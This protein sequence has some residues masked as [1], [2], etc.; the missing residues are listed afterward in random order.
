MCRNVLNEEMTR[1]KKYSFISPTLKFCI[2]GLFIPGFTAA[3][4]LGLQMAIGLFGA[5]CETAWIILWMLTS[6]GAVVAPLIFIRSMNKRLSEGYNLTTKK[7]IFFNITEYTFIQATLAM[8][9]TNRHTL[10]YVTDGQNGLEFVFT[11][12]MAL[13]F[14]VMLSF[15]FDNLRDEKMYVL[16]AGKSSGEKC[17]D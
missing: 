9:F 8:F 15:R 14:L 4:I 16:K 12:W 2:A 7:L 6:I 5:E 13:P 1:K 11:G 17:S 3:A 10:C